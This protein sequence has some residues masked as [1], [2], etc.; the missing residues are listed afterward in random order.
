MSSVKESMSVIRREAFVKIETL[1]ERGA[2]QEDIAQELGVRDRTV[3]RALRRGGP[4]VLLERM[5]LEHLC[6]C[7]ANFG[8]FA[9]R[10]LDHLWLPNMRTLVDF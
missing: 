5:K 8:P 6:F 10:I 4:H 3:R 2:F 1:A 9:N 7:Q